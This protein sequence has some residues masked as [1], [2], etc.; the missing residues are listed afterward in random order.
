M[1]RR[2]WLEALRVHQERVAAHADAFTARRSRDEKH[3][4]HDFLFTYYSFK[5]AKL[6][7]W[8]PPLGVV[9]EEVRAED[10]AAQPWLAAHL[11]ER[12]GGWALNEAR[13]TARV[14]ELAAFVAQLCEGVLARPARFRC[15]GLHEWAMVYQQPEEEIRHRGWALRLPPA[16]LAAFVESQT[17]CCTHYDAYRFFTPAARPR[18][19][20]APDLASRLQNEQAACLHA[21]M[22]LYKW[23][24]KLWPWCGADLVAAAFL[25]ALEGRELDMRASPYDLRALGCLPIAI[26]TPEGRARYEEEQRRLAERAAPLRQRLL[27][28]ARRI[29]GHSRVAETSAH[30]L[31]G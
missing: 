28:V 22:D 20:L 2:D 7:Q 15:Y 31:I 5:P 10:L 6:K 9:L 4:V 13:L 11:V 30:A 23:A 17:L 25:L 24:H 3:P 12:E 19:T 1:S 14:R 8:L 21:N 26:E 18:N 29:A 16:E 27:A